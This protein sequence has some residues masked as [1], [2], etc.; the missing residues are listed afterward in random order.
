MTLSDP[1][2]SRDETF[3]WI[4]RRAEEIRRGWETEGLS[5]EDLL[6]KFAE[7]LG[8]EVEKENA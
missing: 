2:E 7:F 4:M 1:Y 5:R 8:I 3:E 6:K